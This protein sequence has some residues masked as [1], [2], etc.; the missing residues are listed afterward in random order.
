MH[1]IIRLGQYAFCL[2]L[3][4]FASTALA[5]ETNLRSYP[6]PDHGSIQ[7]Q[8]PSSWEDRL[9]QPPGR[10]PPTIEFSQKVGSAFSMLVTPMWPAKGNIKLPDG[11]N[12][13]KS[14]QEGADRIASGAV[15]KMINLIELNG[16][17]AYGYYFSVTD[18]APKPGE[19][20]YLT[21]G[22]VRVGD[23][24]VIFTIL[25][26][27]GQ[28][29][30]ISDGL[31]LI[32]SS[33][34]NMAATA[35]GLNAIEII[36]STDVF[37][38]TVPASRLILTIP[39]GNLALAQNPFGG[40][41]A[42]PGYFYL[43]EQTTNLTISGWFEPANNFMGIK[44]IWEKETETWKRKGL[45]E[46]QNISFFKNANWDIIAYDHL[47][48]SGSCNS[49]IK[50]NWLQAGTWID[51]HISMTSNAPSIENRAKLIDI[52]STFEVKEK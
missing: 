35:S 9:A 12:L 42:H 52:L 4:V 44:N 36:D 39:R 43:R 29:K 26:N 16:P 51:V 6:L 7:F 18:R 31:A 21:Q 47:L 1:C 19:Y 25:T 22:H 48:S 32:K 20:K 23:L 50:A 38:L 28:D 17:S 24:M 41:A 11:D 37:K 46:P 13:R 2:L 49:H 10:L 8:V 27:D 34:Q 40:S 33:A 3:F 15:E 14:V 45:P 5:D 30:I